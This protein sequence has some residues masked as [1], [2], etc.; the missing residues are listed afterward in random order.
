MPN[1]PTRQDFVAHTIQELRGL[2]VEATD[3]LRA[4]LQ[5]AH[6]EYMYI[7]KYGEKSL[8]KFNRVG[9]SLGFTSINYLTGLACRECRVRPWKYHRCSNY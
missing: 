1:I 9:A 7:A 3:S 6:S 8:E 5:A 2:G 4:T